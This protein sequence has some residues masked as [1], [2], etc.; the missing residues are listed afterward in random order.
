MIL[1]SFLEYL[2][3]KYHTRQT[4]DAVN[5]KLKPLM[6]LKFT[7]DVHGSQLTAQSL[8]DVFIL[9]WAWGIFTVHVL[10][11]VSLKEDINGLLLA[12]WYYG[13]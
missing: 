1:L 10:N 3:E 12:H 4:D 7:A 5:V 2:R 13:F 6:V 9:C 8:S 11:P